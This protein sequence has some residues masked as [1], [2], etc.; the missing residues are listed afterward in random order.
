MS[1][2]RTNKKSINKG[3]FLSGVR[4]G[5]PIGLGYFAV[6]F[7]L[8]ITARSAG[9]SPFQGALASLLCNASAGEYAGFTVIASDAAYIEMALVTLI[10]NARYFLMSFAMSQRLSPKTASVHRFLLSF[11]LTDELFAIT[12]N[13][14]GSINPFYTYSALLAPLPCWAVGTAL[15]TAAGNMLPAALVSA[16]GVGLFGMFLASVIPKCKESRAVGG[17]VAACFILSFI[18]SVLPV[19]SDL[20]DGTRTIILTLIISSAAAILLPRNEED[21]NEA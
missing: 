6:S 21:E 7:A 1:H 10:A 13:Q 8:G 11:V 5:I 2:S 20:S 19:I 14:K 17:V 9:L 4:D 3:V 16:L 18:A 15:G 12:M